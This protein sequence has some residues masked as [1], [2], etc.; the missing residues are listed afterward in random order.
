MDYGAPLAVPCVE[1]IEHV[2]CRPDVLPEVL[3]VVRVVVL[4]KG[5]H[6]LHVLADV[7][8]PR[9]KLDGVPGRRNPAKGC[10]NLLDNDPVVVPAL[11]QLAHA[12]VRVDDVEV[13]VV[14]TPSKVLHKILGV[15]LDLGV[16]K[17]VHVVGVVVL[18]ERLRHLV[19]GVQLAG[20]LLELLG[21]VREKALERH[22][23]ACYF[24]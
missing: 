18:P 22:L 19:T 8:H 3:D 10:G 21:R 16:E 5:F 4:G 9:E 6:R 23:R 24:Y 2:R 14:V 17:H 12:R 11:P 20:N 1:H 7:H 13:P 15:H